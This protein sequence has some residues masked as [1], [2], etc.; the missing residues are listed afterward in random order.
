MPTCCVKNC[1][2]SHYN[3][4][5]M[6]MS[7]P[8]EDARKQKWIEFVGKDF[9]LKSHS[10]MCEVHFDDDQWIKKSIKLKPDAIPTLKC[11]SCTCCKVNSKR[12][13][14]IEQSFLSEQNQVPIV[15]SELKASEHDEHPYV[16]KCRPPPPSPSTPPPPPCACHLRSKPVITFS[17]HIFFHS[18]N[19]EESENLNLDSDAAKDKETIKN[20]NMKVATLKKQVSILQKKLAQS[21]RDCK[22]AMNNKKLK[23]LEG[24][25]SDEQIKAALTGNSRGRKWNLEDIEKGL[26][27]KYACGS[28]AYRNVIKESVMP[29]P[30]N[31]TL[32]RRAKQVKLDP[33][34][35]E[36][37]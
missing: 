19:Q 4:M 22:K 18:E 37:I 29:L 1:S 8:K 14:P 33:G 21:R 9:V 10:R 15:T 16:K 3:S 27:L 25:F 12:I 36:D 6:M 34:I 5:L 32:L 13:A 31:R 17:K 2:N 26:K 7:F 11:D 30:S 28:T 24:N 35:L 20:L 23:W